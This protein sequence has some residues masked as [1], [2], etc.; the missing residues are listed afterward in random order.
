[1][2][3]GGKDLRRLA[4]FKYSALELIVISGSVIGQIYGWHLMHINSYIVR[5]FSVW[6]GQLL[7]TLTNS[8][9]LV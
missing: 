7:C 1:M 3:C 6:I 9:A 5:A 8:E 2:V 4:L